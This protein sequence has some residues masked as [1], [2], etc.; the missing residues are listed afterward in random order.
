[1]ED[2]V[3]ATALNTQSEQG[4]D[5]HDMIENVGAL[6][7]SDGRVGENGICGFGGSEEDSTENRKIYSKTELM[8]RK[9]FP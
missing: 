5:Q 3:Q 6:Q 2:L 1:M 9:N 7:G 4:D 8:E